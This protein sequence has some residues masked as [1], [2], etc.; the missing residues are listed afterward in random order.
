LLVKLKHLEEI[1]NHKRKLAA[2]YQQHLKED[3]IKPFVHPDYLD[4]YHI[5]NIRHP[6]RDQ[7]KKYLLDHGIQTEIHYP[8]PPHQQKALQGILPAR[9]FLPGRQAGFPISEEIHRTT[10]SLPCSTAH[11]EED[12]YRIVE[13]MNKF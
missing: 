2:I 11:T 9:T 5:F 4:V 13:I 1:N 8:V 12:I 10:L 3:F 6:K 7:L